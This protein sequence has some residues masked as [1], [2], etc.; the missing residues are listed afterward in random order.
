MWFLVAVCLT[1]AA[2]T[3]SNDPPPSTGSNP[4]S[5]SS[6]LPSTTTLDPTPTTSLATT[7]TSPATGWLSDDP[8][9]TY[10]TISSDSVV[11]VREGTTDVLQLPNLRSGIILDD[12]LI[13]A[14]STTSGTWIWPPLHGS[15]EKVP[16]GEEPVSRLIGQPAGEVTA[17]FHDAARVDDRPVA[18]YS[19]I[20]SETDPIEL[21]MMLFDLAT[22]ESTLVFDKLRRRPS[23]SGEEAADAFVIDAVIANDQVAVLFGFGDGTWVEWYGIDGQ[24]LEA[25]QVVD[26]IEGTILDLAAAGDLLAVGVETDLHRNMD[27]VWVVDMTSATV[28]GSVDPVFD[29]DRLRVPAEPDVSR[30]SLSELSFDGRWV[31]AKVQS[32]EGETLGVFGADIAGGETVMSPDWDLVALDGR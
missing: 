9:Q 32:V 14:L 13:F 21:R 23:L 3:P 27:R 11:F 19:E 2:C 4:G 10:A 24:P 22:G 20:E 5:P 17:W 29:P 15:E 25:L 31:T 7:T 16:D 26:S 1:V 30:A 28:T 12:S 6:T 8:P 18:L